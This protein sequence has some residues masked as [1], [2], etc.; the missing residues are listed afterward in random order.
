MFYDSFAIESLV[1]MTNLREFA[2]INHHTFSQEISTNF[3]VCRSIAARSS[4]AD[5]K[6]TI[7]PDSP[8]SFESQKAQTEHLYESAKR[9]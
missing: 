8:L 1:R 4:N 9:I 6:L 7:E 2:S 3:D 5:C